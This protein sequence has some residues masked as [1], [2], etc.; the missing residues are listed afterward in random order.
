M[1]EGVEGAAGV[2]AV[3]LVFMREAS[4]GGGGRRPV[5]TGQGAHGLGHAGGPAGRGQRAVVWKRE[6]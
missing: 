3:V 5:R 4:P 2:E 6:R 1:A